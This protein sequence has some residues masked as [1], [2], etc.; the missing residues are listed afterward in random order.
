MALFKKKKPQKN[1]KKDLP[2]GIKI[3]WITY[4]SFVFL[5]IV[6][7]IGISNSWIGVGD[8][9]SFEELENP[10]SNLASEIY[11]SDQELLGK[12]Y[13]ENRS[14]VFYSDLSPD[15]VNALIATEDIRFHKHSGVDIRAIMRV[16]KGVLTGNQEGGGST[17]TQQL[18]KNLFPRG[19]NLNKFQLAIRKFQEWVTA[20]KLE[21]NYTKNEILA[22]YLNTV[23]F[24]SQSFG[25]KSA[26]RTFFDTTPDSLKI[27]EAAVLVGLLKAPTKYSPIKNPENSLHRRNTVLGQ[28]EKYGFITET[29]FDSLKSLPL[30]MSKYSIQDHNVGMATYF[31]EYLRMMM[32]AEEPNKK[33]YNNEKKYI[34]DKDLWDTNPLYGWCNKN[35]KA[36]GSNYNIYKDGLR[37]YTTINSKMQKYAEQAVEEH[38]GGYLQPTFYEHWKGVK[39]APWFY[40]TKQEAIDQTL[41]SD[42]KNSERYK[43]GKNAGKSESE[44]KKEF[45]TAVQMRVFSWN[46]EIDTMMTP[47]DSIM[48]YKWFLQVGMMSMEPQTGYVRAYV[49]GINH[50]FFKMDH[51]STTYR[52]VGSTFKPFVYALAMQEGEFSPCTKVPNVPITFELENGQEWSPRNSGTYKDGEMV[53]LKEALAYSI[54]YVSAYLMRRYSPQAVIDL[55]RKMGVKS[56]IPAVYAVA[57]GISELSVYEMVGAKATYAN[58]GVYTEPIFVTRIEDKNGNVIQTFVPNKNEAMSEETAY[59]M[60]QLM[61]GVVESGTGGRLR[62][63]YNIQYPVAG[64][65]GTTND[66]SD[67]WFMGITPDLVT[68]VWV[69]CDDMRIHFRSTALGQG[70]NMA[71]PI[72]AIYMKKVWADRSLDISN[73]DFERPS[74]PLSVETDCAKYNREHPE[75]QNIDM[76]RAETIDAI[77]FN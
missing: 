56:D 4:L 40:Q 5:L 22:M 19:E 44:L 2:K 1:S 11:S 42:M 45:N 69:G 66:N 16:I 48:Y 21:K 43:N 17:I 12:F 3:L 72:W 53:S 35:Q 37:I 32:T 47:M 10:R 58:K 14:N 50:H 38:I 73:G 49:G 39:R 7:F 36:D 74:K 65:T 52:Q 60:L 13:V 55:A 6:F 70:A 54:N 28:M 15:L 27:E 9:P 29:A 63:R 8:M 30:D 71:L 61:K 67:G 62:S 77:G 33:N 31:R 34:R 57:L 46:G 64:K 41:Q 76:W 24:G 75:E 51:V 20:I 23:D 68:G 25:I 18:A 59:L 26:S